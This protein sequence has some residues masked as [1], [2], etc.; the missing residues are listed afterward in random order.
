MPQLF[1]WLVDFEN[2]VGPNGAQHLDYATWP[3][4]LNAIDLVELASSEVDASRTGGSI[5]HR[6]GHVVELIAQLDSCADPVAI[7]SATYQL[8]DEPVIHVGADVLPKLCGF[9]ECANS[10]VH[11][12]VII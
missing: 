3:A 10:N 8:Q 6:R 1:G 4:N 7:A 11:F 2:L 12:P 9:S 5:A